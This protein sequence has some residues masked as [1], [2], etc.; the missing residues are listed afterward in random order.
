MGGDLHLHDL[1][2]TGLTLVAPTG[3]T[4]VRVTLQLVQHFATSTRKRTVTECSR[5]L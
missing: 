2:P 1:R 5:T 4:T 3:A